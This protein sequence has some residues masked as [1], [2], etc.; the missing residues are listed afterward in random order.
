MRSPI[1]NSRIKATVG[2]CVRNCGGLIGDAIESIIDQDFPHELMEAIFVDDGSEDDT[3][4]IIQDYLPKLDMQVKIFHHEWKGLGATRNVVVNS[5]DGEYIIWV[6]GDMI[7]SRDFVR[8]QVE[9]MERNPALGIGKG[10][11]SLC[12]QGTLVGELENIEFVATNLKGKTNRTPLG[13]GGSVYR[14]KAIR[15]IGGFDQN[16]TGS[17]E[18]MDAE[19][20]IM[21][22]GWLLGITSAI[23]YERRRKTWNS[24]WNEY[25]WHGKSV[26]YLL[27]K[28]K[29]LISPYK[30]WPPVAFMIALFRVPVAYKLT[31]RKAA[32]L[33]PL[34]YIF[35]RTAWLT[36]FLTSL[37]E[38]RDNKRKSL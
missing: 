28:S 10:K 3:L 12:E 18:D 24:L 8:K 37:F 21:A 25:R 34:H 32:L 16:I 36:G 1:Y 26:S 11:Y 31:R 5:A 20:R 17:G 19:Y 38:N 22:S 33:L 27:K 35:K 23:F 13:T 29:K 15:Q 2:V 14:V 30:L 7:L 4:S 9:F 6:D